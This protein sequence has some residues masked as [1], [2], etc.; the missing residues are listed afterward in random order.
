MNKTASS[1]IACCFLFLLLASSCNKKNQ[2]VQQGSIKTDSVEVNNVSFKHVIDSLKNEENSLVSCTADTILSV[3]PELVLLLDP[4]YQMVR[5]DS[6]SITVQ[7]KEKWMSNLR[8][9]LSA[10]YDT[11]NLGSDS[12]TIYEK[13]DSVINVAE[14]LYDLDE[15]W[16]TY[17]MIVRNFIIYTFYV[18]R[19]YNLFSQMLNSCD[20]SETK[21]LLYQEWEIY[22][23]LYDTM[24]DISTEFVCLHNWGGSI[25]GPLCTMKHVE[26]SDARREMYSELL[27]MK[28]KKTSTVNV[29]EPLKRAID[30]FFENLN[31]TLKEEIK[32]NSEIWE[33]KGNIADKEYLKT[34]KEEKKRYEETIKE[35]KSYLSIM[36]LKLKKW[37]CTWDKLD[38]RITTDTNHHPERLASKMLLEWSSIAISN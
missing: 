15:D 1:I 13:A 21:K 26:L 32:N 12:L 36:R 37:N 30:V 38:R 29:R 20:D 14:H 5:N 16:S 4:L 6:L 33:E 3:N 17:G 22:E 31:K 28:K 19:E 34:L 23:D 2:V 9:N 27:K 7:E 18:F 8:K 24:R 35:T 11:H 10:Y 25:T